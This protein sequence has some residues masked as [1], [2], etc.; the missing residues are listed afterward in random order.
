MLLYID[1]WEEVEEFFCEFYFKV[2]V[3]GIF[4]IG[5]LEVYG[6]SCEGD[7]FVKVVVSEEFM[8]CGFGGL[9]VGLGLLDI[10]LFLVVKWVCFE[11]CEWVVLVVLCGEKIMVL[12]VIEFFGGFDVVNLK[13]CVV[14]DGDYYCVS[15]SKI[16]IIS[17][18]CV[19][20]YM[21]VVC[22]GGEGFVG[23]SLLLV[24]KG[25]VGFSVGCKLKK[26]G[27]WV[28]DI[29]ELFF[30]DCWVFVENFIGVENVGFV[31]IMVN[32]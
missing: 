17:G 7:L 20:Y 14:C 6:G 22:I 21:V 24:E 8:C 26:M 16:F 3:V 2:G 5:Y 11:V 4:G 13:I 31:C 19:D 25:I 28:L 10:G 32:F 1:E 27:W 15:G 18:V 12:V 29:V 23:I 9:V 30:D